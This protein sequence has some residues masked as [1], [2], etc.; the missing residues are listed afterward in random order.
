MYSFA[1]V[2]DDFDEP[3]VTWHEDE[4]GEMT[5][6][7][8]PFEFSTHASMAIFAGGGVAMMA[9]L[10]LTS[11]GWGGAANAYAVNSNAAALRSM[12]QHLNSNS[13]TAPNPAAPPAPPADVTGHGPYCR[14]C[15]VRA[16]DD[17]QQFCGSCGRSPT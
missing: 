13:P 4:S 9:G 3:S 1:T 8:E 7:E 11:G 6:V 5:M 14:E 16:N 12:G 10:V 15:G 2:D 17:L